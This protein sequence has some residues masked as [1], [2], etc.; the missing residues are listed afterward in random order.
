MRRKFVLKRL[1][2]LFTVLSCSTA[3]K[4]DIEVCIFNAGTSN[5]ACSTRTTSRILP[6]T[7]A[8]NY[9][10]MSPDNLKLLIEALKN[11]D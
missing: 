6:W 2:L 8:D 9:S 4:V 5:L 1:L 10:C 3:P 11:P 7:Q